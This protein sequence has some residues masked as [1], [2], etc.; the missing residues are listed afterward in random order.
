[1][2]FL[3]L[4]ITTYKMNSQRNSRQTD[5]QTDT[6]IDIK[7]T[8]TTLFQEPTGL[9]STLTLYINPYFCHLGAGRS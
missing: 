6:D 4:Y 5:G 2:E 9:C 7:S 1:M 8:C 3:Y